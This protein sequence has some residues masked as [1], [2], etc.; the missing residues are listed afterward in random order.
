LTESG[1]GGLREGTTIPV[2]GERFVLIGD[3]DRYPHFVAVRGSRGMV[4]N[5]SEDSI[6]LRLDDQLSGVEERDNE[7]V[8]RA[9]GGQDFW[10]RVERLSS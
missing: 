6:S 1:S 8:W 3:G 7:V 4:T 5:V 2:V 9:D 10:R